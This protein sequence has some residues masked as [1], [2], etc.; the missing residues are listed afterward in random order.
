M[1]DNKFFIWIWGMVFAT[2][3]LLATVSACYWYGKHKV[4]VEK[5][6]QEAQVPSTYTTIWVKPTQ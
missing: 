6:Y 4:M 3:I 5:G 1:D 2:L